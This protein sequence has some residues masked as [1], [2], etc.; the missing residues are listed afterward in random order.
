MC[1]TR[2]SPLVVIA[3][4][5]VQIRFTRTVTERGRSIEYLYGFR[6]RSLSTVVEWVS[7]TSSMTTSQPYEQRAA[8][9][10]A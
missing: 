4:G 6:P 8:T 5:N 1:P 2:C 9:R 3:A 7:K 10:R